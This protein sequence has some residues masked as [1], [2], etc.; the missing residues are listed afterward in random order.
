MVR[1]EQPSIRISTEG[2]GQ[3][4]LP[5]PEATR[6]RELLAETLQVTRLFLRRVFCPWFDTCCVGS[7]RLWLISEFSPPLHHL[8]P[9]NAGFLLHDGPPQRRV[10]PAGG[11]FCG[12]L[13]A[14]WF[15]PAGVPA[16]EGLWPVDLCPLLLPA[17]GLSS[18]IPPLSSAVFIRLLHL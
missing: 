7:S 18:C 13:Q 5:L 16:G 1:R 9:P 17:A 6:L 14:S 12:P 8:C 10:P 3:A 4:L 11:V 2:R 15:S